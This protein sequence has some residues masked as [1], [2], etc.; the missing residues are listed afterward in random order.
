M[1]FNVENCKVMG[2]GQINECP[3]HALGGTHLKSEGRKGLGGDYLW[4]LERVGST[5]TPGGYY[6]PQSRYG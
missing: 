1:G 4:R 5:R 6:K 2:L 3:D